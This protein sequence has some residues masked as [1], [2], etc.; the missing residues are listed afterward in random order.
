MNR[1]DMLDRID[2][3]ARFDVAIIGGGATGLGVAIDAAA[4]GYSTVLLE[5]SDFAKATSSRSTKLIHG[6]VRYLEQ[7]NLSLVFEALR[8]R[9]RLLQNAPHLVHDRSFVIPT[10]R[11]WEK[12]YYGT[13]LKLYDVIAGA[14]SFGGSHLL[15][16]EETLRRL[17]TV[18][19]DGLGGGVLYHD[20]QFDDARLAINMAQTATEHGAALVNY[21]K[22][23]A[24][25]KR[26]GRVDG[27]IA[28]DLENDK[29][30]QIPA[31][32]VVN[33]AGIFSD[34]VR[35]LSAD[36][37]PPRMRPSQGIH[38]VLDRSFLSGDSA[39]MIPKTDDGRVLFA[40]PWKDIVIVGTTDTPVDGPSLEPRP[41]DEEIDFV[42]EHTGRY[43]QHPPARGDLRSVFAGIRPLVSKSDRGDTSDISR[44]HHLSVAP[45]GL[46]TIAGGKWTTYR[47][48][49]EETVDR[50]I[51]VGGLTPQPCET[52]SLRLHGYHTQA[53]TFGAL[54]AYG[55]DAPGLR[56]LMQDQ[57]ELNTPLHP[58][59][60]IRKGQVVWAARYEMARTVDDVLARRTRMVL[61]DAEASLAMAPTV[62]TLLADEL[63]R[64]SAWIDT[65][66]DAFTDIA[67]GYLA[68]S[69][70][71]S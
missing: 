23:E 29:E 21:M 33:A 13:G 35:Q 18:R 54:S 26:N 43:L 51:D 55:S 20:G 15:S 52:Q 63:N 44:A 2:D 16:R 8:E 69:P 61:R 6:G 38:I 48:M 17:P 45:D 36:D 66:V 12:P 24:L 22:V 67:H 5:M 53:H 60:D 32:V 71:Y 1:R 34:R 62:A 31:R 46:L 14:D 28:H 47:N 64:S 25:M 50:A 10:Y 70:A 57:E 4:R 27:V 65:Q 40:L 56:R 9:E 39:V 30:Y 19:P 42:L 7:G 11:W 59:Y 37:S 49:A 58:N 3:T 41:L 68:T